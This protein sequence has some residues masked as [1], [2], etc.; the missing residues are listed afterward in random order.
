[1]GIEFG[2]GFLGLKERQSLYALSIERLQN[3][4]S[5]TDLLASFQYLL[6][7]MSA[8]SEGTRAIF[9]EF[10]NRRNQLVIYEVTPIVEGGKQESE[11]IWK[12]VLWSDAS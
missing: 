5:T 1:M 8:L 9:A 12:R 4:F 7:W 6:T 11:S 10:L 2:L 3:S